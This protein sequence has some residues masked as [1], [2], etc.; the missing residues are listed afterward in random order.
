MDP[1]KSLGKHRVVDVRNDPKAIELSTMVTGLNSTEVLERIKKA[2]GRT[3]LQTVFS[4]QWPWSATTLGNKSAAVAREAGLHAEI[5]WL[6]RGSKHL[7]TRRLN[8]S[9]GNR[10]LKNLFWDLWPS[11]EQPSPPA[12]PPP[13]ADD[14]ADHDDDNASKGSLSPSPSPP[15]PERESTDTEPPPAGFQPGAFISSRYDVKHTL[16]AGGFGTTWLAHD[17]LSDLD[18]VLKVPHEDDGGAIRHELELAFQIVHPN[19]CQAFPDRD[20]ETGHPFLVMQHGGLDLRKLL[21][22]RNWEPFPLSFAIHVL[23]S[24]A[25]ALDHVHSKRIL[26]LDVS[27]MNILV[28]EEDVVRLTDF[29]ASARGKEAATKPGTHT[30]QANAIS[31]LNALWSAP[32]CFKGVG[33]TRSDQYSLFLVFCTMLTG[34]LPTRVEDLPKPPFE[35]LSDVQNAA[36]VRALS[37]DPEARFDTCGDAA[38]AVADGLGKVPQRVLVHD[39]ENYA[40]DLRNRLARELAR[41]AATHTRRVGGVI[42]TGGALERL[43]L[44]MYLWLAGQEKFEAVIE[45]K[46]KFTGVNSVYR[47]T[48]GM[49][50]ALLRDRAT[51]KSADRPEIAPLITDLDTPGSRLYQL[52]RLRNEVAH[53]G[54]LSPTLYQASVDVMTLLDEYL[55]ALPKT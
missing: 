43:L 27:P 1:R 33:R 8:S 46:K 9:A 3:L 12:P 13:P 31:S 37:L 28:D 16:G 15:E 54:V 45:L 30:V 22:Q 5:K 38:R 10:L 55:A 47:A 51:S 50:V 23:T 7:V 53:Q 19:I 49:L 24:V 42:K 6:T 35:I 17:R 39:L 20:D 34:R 36:V 40:R 14:D 41:P 2:H 11:E 48:A 32:E 52:I 26:H 25:E 44:A 29:G 21:E 4:E 18:V